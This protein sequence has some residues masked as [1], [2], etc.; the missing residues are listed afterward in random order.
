MLADGFLASTKKLAFA[1]HLEGIVG[2]LLYA[3]HFQRIFVDDVLVLLRI[4]QPVENIP[5]ERLEERVQK[6]AP[7]LRLVIL[8]RQVFPAVQFEIF[9]QLFDDFRCGHRQTLFCW[10]GLI[11]T[12]DFLQKAEVNQQGGRAAALLAG[13]S[14][15]QSDCHLF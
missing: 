11:I 4:S 1:S 9:N 8:P 6:L 14:R 13:D 5:A 3:F 15:F 2:R 12:H 10:D 7:Q